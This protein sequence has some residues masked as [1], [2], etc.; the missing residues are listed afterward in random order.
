MSKLRSAG[1]LIAGCAGASPEWAAAQALFT[2]PDATVENILYLPD[3]GSGAPNPLQVPITGMPPGA[4]PQSIAWISPTRA[5]VADATNFRVCV[6][7]TDVLAV[8]DTITTPQYEGGGTIA[9][10]PDGAYALAIGTSVTLNVIEAPFAAASAIR[11]LDLDVFVDRARTQATVFDHAGRAFIASYNLVAVLDPPYTEVAFNIPVPHETFANPTMGAIAITPDDGQLLVSR[12][13]KVLVY[14]A[15]FTQASL[16][17]SLTIPDLSGPGSPP[18]AT[19]GLAMSPTGTHALVAA[20]FYNPNVYSIAAPF[21][22]NSAVTPI[23]PPAGVTYLIGF[24][25]IGFSPDGS[26]AIVA[27]GDSSH[28]A[29]TPLIRNASSSAPVWVNIL[30]GGGRGDGAVR[31]APRDDLIFRDGFDGE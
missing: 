21:S 30:I 24:E 20:G 3:P 12:D 5:L 22:Q 11:T 18:G 1:F 14:T 8:V 6:V 26:L 17:E 28:R 13:E 15:P 31:F 2:T 29:D 9:I 10:S 25:D 7:D 27:G 16:P 23:T 4:K 19:D